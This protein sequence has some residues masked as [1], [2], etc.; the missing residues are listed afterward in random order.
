MTM[1]GYWIARFS[2]GWKLTLVALVLSD[3]FGDVLDLQ[4]QLDALNG[5]DSGLGDGRGDASGGEIL[6]EG[7]G[8]SDS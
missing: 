5:G 7:D 3:L 1:D 4:Q 8:I 2:R 6:H